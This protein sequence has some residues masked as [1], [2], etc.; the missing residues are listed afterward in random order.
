MSVAW[1]TKLSEDRD[2]AAYRVVGAAEAAVFL[3]Q[4]Y[5]E[6]FSGLAYLR[7]E[8]IKYKA[9]QKELDRAQ[10]CQMPSPESHPGARDGGELCGRPAVGTDLESELPACKKH[11]GAA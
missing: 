2:R 1:E 7:D 4:R 11:M 3:A 8:L 6:T 5:G 9:A 10:S